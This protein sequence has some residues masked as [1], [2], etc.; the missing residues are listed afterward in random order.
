M[1][2]NIDI[3]INSQFPNLPLKPVWSYRNSPSNFRIVNYP[4]KIG[5]WTLTNL[6]VV[7]EYPDNSIKTIQCTKTKVDSHFGFGGS[8][9]WVG[10]IDGCGISG[11]KEKGLTI[12]A[13][14]LDENGMPTSQPYVLGKADLY[15]MDEQGEIEPS[16]TTY[17]VTYHDSI[18]QNPKIGDT[19]F[20]EG[21][22]LIFD[23]VNWKQPLSKTSEL[24]NDSGFLTEDDLSAYATFEDLEGYVNLD[25]TLPQNPIV[26]DSVF[27]NGVLKIWDGTTWQQT[28]TKTSQIQN[29]SGF[30]TASQVPS[31]NYDIHEMGES[32][33]L[34]DEAINTLVEKNHATD[35]QGNYYIPDDEH[36]P[37]SHDDGTCYVSAGH[38]Y[39]MFDEMEGW[40]LYIYNVDPETGNEW[41]FSESVGGNKTDTTIACDNLTVTIHNSLYRD[42]LILPSYVEGKA[43]DFLFYLDTD[44]ETISIYFTDC[45]ADGQTLI[46]F[47]SDDDEVFGLEAGK[48]IMA[49]SEISPHT[50]LVHKSKLEVVTQG[51]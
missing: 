11:K 34:Q 28:I 27:D 37:G 22:L 23:G 45:E 41:E 19:Y 48:S 15:I 14:G 4:E 38:Y 42:G 26:G 20:N 50:F 21:V 44:I 31:T 46:T 36:A 18:P 49:F 35:N 29:D 40:S 13:T 7:A 12:F 10:T 43:R 39:I 51:E 1:V 3:K 2:G 8:F 32:Y 24:E 30:I 47:V 25:T 6:Y 33:L 17:Y 5:E 16:E 9:A